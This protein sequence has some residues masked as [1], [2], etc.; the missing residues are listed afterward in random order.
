LFGKSVQFTVCTLTV[1]PGL[2]LWNAAAM[3]SQYLDVLLAGP[4]P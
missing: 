4:V 2:A 3:A 1:M